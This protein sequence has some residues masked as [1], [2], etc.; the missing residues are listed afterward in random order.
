MYSHVSINIPAWIT[1]S[2]RDNLKCATSFSHQQSS[3]QLYP[4]VIRLW[5]LLPFQL[6]NMKDTDA[7]G[8]SLTAAVVEKMSSQSHAQVRRL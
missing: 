5:N 2:H 6:R 8:Q 1:L 7:F 4:R 3:L